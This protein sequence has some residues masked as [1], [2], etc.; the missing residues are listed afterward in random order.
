MAY[1]IGIKLEQE[2]EVSLASLRHVMHYS[3]KTSHR[4]K[5]LPLF[6]T[7]VFVN[8]DVLNLKLKNDANLML[9]NVQIVLQGANFL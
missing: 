2:T 3:L 8:V 9:A 6:K 1:S 4:M 7:L 5:T